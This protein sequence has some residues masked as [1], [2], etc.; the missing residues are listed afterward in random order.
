MSNWD[1]R[2]TDAEMR[3]FGDRPNE[4][5]RQVMA[6]SD[7]TPAS[8]L[9]IGDGDGRNGT[10]LASLGLDVTAIDISDVANGQAQAHDAAAGV[11]VERITA[12]LATWTPETGRVWDAAFMMYLQCEA[13]VRNRAARVAATALNPGGWFA[14]EGFAP[15]NN[16]TRG[17][18][19][20]GKHDLLYER[21]DLLAALDSLHVVEAFKGWTHLDEGA[22]HQGNG[23]VLRLLARRPAE[24]A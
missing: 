4:Y 11:T 1:N 18:L 22:K 12:D 6:R 10:W 13:D 14:A 17:E 24:A 20:P 3:L 5:L 15:S 19:G 23:W 8:A 2:Y 7:V 9:M 21:D 16:R